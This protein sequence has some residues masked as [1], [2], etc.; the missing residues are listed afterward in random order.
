M[1]VRPQNCS[2]GLIRRVLVCL[3][4]I[5]VRSW[6][7]LIGSHFSSCCFEDLW[8]CPGTSL[9]L[10]ELCSSWAATSPSGWA[11]KGVGRNSDVD[12]RWQRVV[13]SV[14]FLPIFQ[15]WISCTCYNRNLLT[16]IHVGLIMNVMVLSEFCPTPSE[17]LLQTTL[18][19]W[20]VF[21][22]GMYCFEYMIQ[23]HSSQS[24][25]C[26][27]VCIWQHWLEKGGWG[28]CNRGLA[29]GRWYN[30][31]WGRG[32]WWESWMRL[33]HDTH[34]MWCQFSNS[35][36]EPDVRSSIPLLL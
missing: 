24:R 3:S 35:L 4:C 6:F 36:S 13:G 29:G 15:G 5:S 2:C 16:P 1:W 26:N 8:G 21:Q 20:T 12:P 25:C 28:G 33:K 14:H 32:M 11:V 30:K 18:S 9:P 23:Q 27:G 19:A 10:L 17:Q 34:V 7:W 22:M 31:C